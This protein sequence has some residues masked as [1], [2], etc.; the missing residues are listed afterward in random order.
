M[1]K[2]L[3]TIVLLS[4][5][6]SVSAQGN[7]KTETVTIKTNIYC[8]HC[9]QCESCGGRFEREIPFIKGIKDYSFDEKAMMLLLTYNPKQTTPEKLRE[10]ISKIGFDAD[11]VKADPKAVAKL[12]DC[13]KKV[14]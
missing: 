14:N 2:Y 5:V 1:N 7:K 8:D 4:I 3:L 13:C 6:F 12:D 10:A 11:D 9:K